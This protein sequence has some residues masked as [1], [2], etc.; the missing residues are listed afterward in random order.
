M[1]VFEFNFLSNVSWGLNT[2]YFIIYIL[3]FIFF[4]KELKI[5]L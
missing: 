4:L 1:V 3:H 2:K 5:H